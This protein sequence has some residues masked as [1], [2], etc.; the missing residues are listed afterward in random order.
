[1]PRTTAALDRIF[2]RKAA[3]AAIVE[4]GMRLA[5]TGSAHSPSHLLRVRERCRRHTKRGGCD[6]KLEH[7]GGKAHRAIARLSA[8]VHVAGRSG[9]P[10]ANAVRYA[11]A[12]LAR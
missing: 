11:R 1:M 6:H 7:E 10:G 9:D 3:Q 2:V 4:D 12:E 8:A 5:A